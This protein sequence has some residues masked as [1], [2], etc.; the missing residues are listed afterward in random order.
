MTIMKRKND[1]ALAL[2]LCVWSRGIVVGAGNGRNDAGGE[3][4]VCGGD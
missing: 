2:G 4:G 1:D 3:L